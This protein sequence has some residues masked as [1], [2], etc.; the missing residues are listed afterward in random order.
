MPTV[1]FTIKSHHH[2]HMALTEKTYLFFILHFCTLVS[3]VSESE[4]FIKSDVYPKESVIL[5]SKLTR[6]RIE[7]ATRCI[8]NEK[9]TTITA[10][11]HMKPYACN[12]Y[13]VTNHDNNANVSNGSEVWNKIEGAKETVCPGPFRQIASG[14]YYA[15]TT[16]SENWDLAR[17]ACQNLATAGDETDLAD[18]HD[19]EVSNIHLISK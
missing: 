15:E 4:S 10:E 6:S 2:I 13:E 11:Q 7:C 5:S 8:Q 16:A 17:S 1:M 19:V 14:C 18:I 12:I 3:V 9:C